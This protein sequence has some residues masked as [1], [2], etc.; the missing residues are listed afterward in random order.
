[1]TRRILLASVTA[2]A[3]LLLAWY[4]AWSPPGI[5][6]PWL[7]LA[8]LVGPLLIPAVLLVLARPSAPFW[9][10]FVLL[11]H[12]CHGVMEAWTRP[13]VR[14][15]ALAEIMVVLLVYAVLLHDGLRARRARRNS[16]GSAR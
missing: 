16:A 15:L 2:L 7:V 3:L 14:P 8:V 9:T 12:F 1:M 11:M 5:L 6:P 4:G 13:D 10:G